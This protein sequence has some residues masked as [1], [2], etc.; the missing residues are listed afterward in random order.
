MKSD[1]KKM[2]KDIRHQLWSRWHRTG[3]LMAKYADNILLRDAGI[4]YQQFTV[5]MAMDYIA[6]SPT[7]TD[8]ASRLDRNTNTLS[9]IL[10]RMEKAGL[11]KKLRDLPDRRLVRAVMTEEGKE[12][13]AAA[14]K[15]ALKVVGKLTKTFSEEELQTFVSLIDRL[16]KATNEELD[17]F[18]TAK[19]AR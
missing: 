10:D 17:A 18:K 13:Y 19:D 8:L 9:T 2:S 7:A 5:L 14:L 1:S 4:S 3:Y 6:N 15:I 12:K 11:V 16:R